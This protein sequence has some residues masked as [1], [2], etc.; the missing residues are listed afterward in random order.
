MP[1]WLAAPAWI[2]WAVTAGAFLSSGLREKLF[3]HKT[4]ALVKKTLPPI[5]QTEQEALDAGDVWWEGDLFRG[6]PDWDK[7]LAMPK[8][9]LRADEQAFLDNQVT[10]LCRMLDDWKIVQ[11]ERDLP[12][13]V[14]E[15]IRNQG[16]FGLVIDKQYGGLGFSALAHSTIV[17][18]IA[19]RSLSA[20]VNVMVPNS[21]GPAELIYHYGTNEQRDYYLPRL[22]KGIEVP[23]FGLTA[24]EAGSDAGAIPDT[25]VI[26]RGTYEGKEIIGMR[27][28]FDKR[29][30]TLAP[31]ATIIGVAFK[32]YDPE[33]L[34]GTKTDLG[35]TLALVPA[36]HPNV[37]SDTRHFP[38]NLAFLNGP[39]RGKDVFLP[40]DDIIGG[41]AMAGHG[42][43]MLMECLSIGRSISL[44]ALSHAVGAVSYRMTGAYAR[45]RKQ[46][47]L[48]IA[49]FEGV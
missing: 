38:M 33:H 9:A 41:P 42:W 16:F 8:P 22:A 20:A 24:S 15:Y 47:K 17:S 39:V 46:F 31:M 11:E 5:S 6:T 14:W 30:I 21:L 29:Y 10:T 12:A 37:Q 43:R 7:L 23:C 25:G 27:L 3:M 19:S 13:E 48:P 45:I 36:S 2:I 32:L 28:N 34:L 44:P 40:L 18:R 35:V 49:H 26:C 4:F 1:W